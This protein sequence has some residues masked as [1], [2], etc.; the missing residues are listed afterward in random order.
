MN[1]HPQLVRMVGPPI[2][3]LLLL[4]ALAALRP[5]C[6]SDLKGETPAERYVLDKLWKFEDPDLKEFSDGDSSK[7]ELSGEFIKKLLTS[8]S[9]ALPFRR[10]T[11][12]NAVIPYGLDLGSEE[13]HWD[14]SLIDCTF[15]GRVSFENSHFANALDISGS[16]FQL[17]VVFNGATMENFIAEHCRF[18]VFAWFFKMRVNRSFD[19]SDSTFDGLETTF[20]DVQVGGDFNLNNS[21]FTSTYIRFNDMQVEG[22]FSAQKCVFNYYRFSDRSE[23]RVNF[24]GAHF[25][26]FFLNESTFETISIVDFTR[27]QADYISFDG[28]SFI[29]PIKINLHLMTFKLLRPVNADQLRFL[30]SDYNAEFYTDVE[31]ALRTHGYPDEADKIFLAKKRAERRENCKSF[32]RQCNKGK[33]ALSWFQD[34]LAGYGKS[35]QNLLGWSVG[36]LFVGM[37]VF[38]SEQGMRTK[39]RKDGPHYA[40]RYRAFWYSL[41]LFLPI[42]K[43]GEAETWTPKDHR[44]WAILYKKVHIIVGSLFVPIGLA[45]WT[46][47]IK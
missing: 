23:S 16:S 19:I 4:L 24:S 29:A 5:V 39:D 42:I 1:F 37:L 26:D 46:G 22:S 9:V 8:S 32:L 11:I 36:F 21:K 10:L 35:L 30:L 41:D 43:L 27:M 34:L 25:G 20:A 17:S 40:G 44:R 33:W 6:A 18:E 2:S 7:R 3:A 31:T 28:V 12:K 14:V 47:I 15:Q 38:R 13:I 45:A